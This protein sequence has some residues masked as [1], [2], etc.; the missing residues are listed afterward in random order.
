MARIHLI[1]VIRSIPVRIRIPRIRTVLFLVCIR[2]P[3][4]VEVISCMVPKH[5]AALPDGRSVRRHNRTFN[6]LFLHEKTGYVDQAQDAPD[7]KKRGPYP[8]AASFQFRRNGPAID[9][10]RRNDAGFPLPVPFGECTVFS[11][12]SPVQSAHGFLPAF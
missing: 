6:G 3:V 10:I 9:V 4:M 1:H 2:E 8:G 5:A 12:Q 11:I 7:D